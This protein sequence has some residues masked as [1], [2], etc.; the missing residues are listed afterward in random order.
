M[1]SSVC[2]ITP[3]LRAFPVEGHNTG[4]YYQF[5]MYAGLLTFNALH[6]NPRCIG[7]GLC[8][9][10]EKSCKAKFNFAEFPFHALR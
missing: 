5:L 4:G 1:R 9:T 3:V 2:P 6:K 8:A 10:S 7:P